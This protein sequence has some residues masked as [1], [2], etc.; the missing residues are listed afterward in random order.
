MRRGDDEEGKESFWVGREAE[1]RRER[2]RWLCGE[3]VTW[4]CVVQRHGL[5]GSVVSLAAR[6]PQDR[7]MS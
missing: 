3:K 5:A 1:W 4:N 7:Q 2:L 6:R